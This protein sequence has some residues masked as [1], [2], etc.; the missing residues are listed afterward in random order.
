MPK[1]KSFNRQLLYMAVMI[2]IPVSI[3]LLLNFQTTKIVERLC[4]DN[5]I[6]SLEEARN[7]MDEQFRSLDNRV[8]DV[9]LNKNTAVMLTADSPKEAGGSVYPLY[10][11]SHGLKNSIYA[12]D[13]FCR[14]YQ[15]ISRSNE[16]IYRNNSFV[17]GLEFFFNKSANYPDMTY[18]K[19]LDTLFQSKEKFFIPAQT[20]S[21]D[22][23]TYSAVTYVFPLNYGA[24]FQRADAVMLFII[25]TKNL[26]AI[27]ETADRDD[28]ATMY[29]LTE[30]GDVIFSSNSSVS[31]EYADKELLLAAESTGKSSGFFETSDNDYLF[32]YTISPYN[33][34]VYAAQVPRSLV[35]AQMYTVSSTTRIVLA[36]YLAVSIVLAVVFAYQMSKPIR[37]IVDN[38]LQ[39]M[40]ENTLEMKNLGEFDFIA[41]NML[42]LLKRNKTLE[43][44]DK[45]KSAALADI[46]L[47]RLL[48]GHAKSSDL[49][50][51]M[52]EELLFPK[53]W[54][55]CCVVALKIPAASEGYGK[56]FPIFDI[57]KAVEALPISPVGICRHLHTTNETV[58]A[59]VYAFEE[60]DKQA[61]LELL[62]EELADID[63]CVFEKA[64]AHP[65]I[66]IGRFY[67]DI[68][69]IYFSYDQALYAADLAS[70]SG[71]APTPY[72]SSYDEVMRASGIYFYPIDL[73]YRLVNCAKVGEVRETLSVFEKIIDENFIMRQLT[74]R[75]QRQLCY[76][77]RA[78]LLKTCDELRLDVGFSESIAE[79]IDKHAEPEAIV[80]IIR[81]AFGEIASDIFNKKRSHNTDLKERIHDFIEERYSDPQMCVAM[82]AEEFGLSE[83]YFSQFFKMQTGEPFSAHL[84]KLRILKARDLIGADSSI[85]IETL[86]QMVGYNSSNTFRRAFKRVVGVSPSSY[87]QR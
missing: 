20:V 73:E 34:V 23:S 64:G 18:E 87:K 48:S 52:L 36:V 10:I 15:I 86:Y 46:A 19:W 49:S 12:G 69:D 83:S 32:A 13:D 44:S 68:Y 63:G 17:S 1:K 66:G 14:E 54:E 62:M 43:L 60:N 21:L 4:M 47:D 37:M 2:V 74:Q 70:Y 27:L 61:N 59:A 24:S 71:G 33:G 41:E 26:S 75:M 39:S 84:E 45:D 8:V 29:I 40:P 22:G 56:K 7:K 65:Y 81:D 30:A 72:I 79:E 67:D 55:R 77:I 53:N 38:M 78:T 31:G 76:D 57:E 85:E 5:Y 82:V 16:L 28:S 42:R 50:L 11:Y 3:V 9:L 80:R 35:L 6:S 58:I 51:D 25:E